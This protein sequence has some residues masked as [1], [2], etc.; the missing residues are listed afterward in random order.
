MND[1]E[2]AEY[3]RQLARDFNAAVKDAIQAGLRVAVEVD[4]F[5][6]VTVP[7]IRRDF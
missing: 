3:L 4:A 6:K 2:R 5:G 1:K 7:S